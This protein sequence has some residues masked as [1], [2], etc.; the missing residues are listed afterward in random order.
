M[1]PVVSNAI[2][3]GYAAFTTTAYYCKLGKGYLDL[4][5]KIM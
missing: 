1:M 5:G 2:G 3:T 4:D